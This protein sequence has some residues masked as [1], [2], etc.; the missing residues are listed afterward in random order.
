MNFLY[1]FGCKQSLK[2]PQNHVKPVSFNFG[3]RILFGQPRSHQKS[4]FT[5]LSQI[6]TPSAIG[7]RDWS[8]LGH[9]SVHKSSYYQSGRIP[10]VGSGFRSSFS[11][12]IAHWNP[13]SGL[14]LSQQW[15]QTIRSRSK[16]IW[17][18]GSCTKS[19]PPLLDMVKCILDRPIAC[20]AWS[21]PFDRAKLIH[22]PVH[23]IMDR[24]IFY[25]PCPWLYRSSG[26]STVHRR[27]FKIDFFGYFC[28]ILL[29]FYAWK[30]K[31][32]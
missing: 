7:S 22:S 14:V 19:E 31:K 17:V 10:V 4:S 23:R 15:I 26:Q 9:W 16:S 12:Q 8:I 1:F 30:I 18:I 21:Q 6:K 3:H 25:G 27:L 32:I 11:H 2:T 29:K 20:L 5:S 13:L 28:L 24:E